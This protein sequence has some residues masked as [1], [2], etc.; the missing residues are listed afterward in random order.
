MFSSLIT[1]Y[2][3]D[4]ASFSSHTYPFRSLF[5]SFISN[6]FHFLFPIFLS[7]FSF[8][9]TLSVGVVIYFHECFKKQNENRLSFSSD[10]FLFY[11]VVFREKRNGRFY[12]KGIVFFSWIATNLFISLYI[13]R[14]ATVSGYYHWHSLA[15]SNL[16]CPCIQAR[17][18]IEGVVL[19]FICIV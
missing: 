1:W 4:Y 18:T 17:T 5:I 7:S 10:S 13:Y 12:K 11:F 16:W 2:R 19:Y 15:S 6:S 3:S 9:F 8:V 14:S